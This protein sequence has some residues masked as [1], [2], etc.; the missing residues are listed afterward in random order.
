MSVR[1]FVAS[2]VCCAWLEAI[3]PQI[4]AAVKQ[5]DLEDL[6]RTVNR[7]LALAEEAS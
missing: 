1:A 2:V 5:F 3:V 6:V 7:I 4:A